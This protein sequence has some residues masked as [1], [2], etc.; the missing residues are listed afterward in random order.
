MA[1]EEIYLKLQE[2]VKKYGIELTSNYKQTDNLHEMEMEY[3]IQ[4]EKL[5]QKEEKKYVENI[6]MCAILT[7]DLLKNKY[8]IDPIGE[9]VTYYEDFKKNCH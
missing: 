7:N 5:H 8:S 1:D 6:V 2:L 4:M 3:A 9:L